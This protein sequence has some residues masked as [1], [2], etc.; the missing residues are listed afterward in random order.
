MKIRE[1]IEESIEPLLS[2]KHP[3]AL[4]RHLELS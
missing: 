4:A 1:E 2:G 3:A